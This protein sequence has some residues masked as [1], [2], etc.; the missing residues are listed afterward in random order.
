MPSP[1]SSSTYG[2]QK[3][4]RS[5]SA[6]CY[7]RS[8]TVDLFR[9]RRHDP[10]GAP[11]IAAKKNA[12]RRSFSLEQAE[13]LTGKV[14]KGYLVRQ[15]FLPRGMTRAALQPVTEKFRNGKSRNSDS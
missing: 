4:H 1:S 10:C 11:A 6:H 12:D 2:R 5:S 13:K 7:K 14:R 8:R 15:P 9:L 3:K